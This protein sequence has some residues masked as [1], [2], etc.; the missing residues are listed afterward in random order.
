MASRPPR[1]LPTI[2]LLLAAGCGPDVSGPVTVGVLGPGETPGT[3]AIVPTELP[4]IESLAHL[5]GPGVE[6][7]AGAKLVLDHD[8]IARGIEAGELLTL[9]DVKEAMVRRRG[10][11]P[12]AMFSPGTLESA[13]GAQTVWLAEDYHSLGMATA[14]A[15]VARARRAAVGAG[16]PP[17]CLA[18]L[19]T[20]YDLTFIERAGGV[21]GKQHDNAFF[22][23]LMG[24]IFFLPHD[25][26]PTLAMAMNQGIIAHEYSHGIWSCLVDDFEPLSWRTL[27][28]DGPAQAR[29]A[30]FNEGL[31]D[32]FGAWVTGDPDFIALTLPSESDRRDVSVARLYT[33]AMADAEQNLTGFDPYLLGAVLAS[34]L[35]RIRAESEDPGVAD[36]WVLAALAALPAALEWAIQRVGTFTV[37]DFLAVLAAASAGEGAPFQARVCRILGERFAAAGPVN[38]CP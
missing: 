8:E 34:A 11:P 33:Q 17:A 21:G 20:Y 24:S 26:F 25:A 10:R 36:R 3:Y 15:H 32:Y 27:S 28:L 29:L 35:W 7:L 13:G 19:P 18:R 4:E 30:G 9:D 23:P 2:L 14:Y 12:R 1:C 5:R 38:G 6:V 37:P 16:L 31:A 22:M